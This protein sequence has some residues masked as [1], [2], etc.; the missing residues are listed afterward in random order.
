MNF[1]R[2]KSQNRAINLDHVYDARYGPAGEG[3]NDEGATVPTQ[4]W[5]NLWMSPATEALTC[6]RGEDADALWDY[7]NRISGG[8]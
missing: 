8:R 7:I 6:I 2:L 4:S 1:Y 5:L 3:E